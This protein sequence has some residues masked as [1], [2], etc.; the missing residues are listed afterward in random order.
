MNTTIQKVKKSTNEGKNT[1]EIITVILGIAL[2]ITGIH[3]GVFEI[4][5]GNTPTNG[6]L[7][8]SIGESHRMW[9]H[10]ND[11]A[12]TLIPNFLVTGIVTV[13]VGI[14]IIIW[15]VFYINRKYGLAGFLILFITLT[16]TGGGIGFIPFYILT[17]LYSKR[18]NKELR[19]WKNILSANIRKSISNTWLIAAIASAG[20]LIIGLEI[21]VFGYIPGVTD[22]EKIL[23]ICWSF[24]FASLLLINYSFI[25]GFAYCISNQILMNKDV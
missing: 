16:L 17:W 18:M 19:W 20:F 10:G 21:S 14:L 2:A 13:L 11:P 15:T 9:L 4:L 8:E 23:T 7:I 12:F 1:P 5:Q 22:P 3:H 24:L 25:S 6:M